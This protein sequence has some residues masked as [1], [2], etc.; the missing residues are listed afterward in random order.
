VFILFSYSGAG[1]FF[2]QTL[3]NNNGYFFYK[4]GSD[5]TNLYVIV[6]NYIV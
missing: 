3:L 1:H 2:K 6:F 5:G 4:T